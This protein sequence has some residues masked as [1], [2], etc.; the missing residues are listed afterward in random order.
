MCTI[1]QRLRKRRNLLKRTRETFKKKSNNLC[2]F[3][4]D[5]RNKKERRLT[6]I[7]N[8]E[9]RVSL[10]FFRHLAYDVPEAFDHVL[11]TNIRASIECGEFFIKKHP[12]N[13]ADANDRRN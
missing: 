8:R 13:V 3:L 11:K 10:R 6:R 4:W 5:L 2:S 9:E 1:R 7:S 12:A